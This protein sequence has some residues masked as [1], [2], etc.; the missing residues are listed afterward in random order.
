MTDA[1]Q[2]S[3][4]RHKLAENMTSL[5]RLILSV[6]ATRIPPDAP[7]VKDALK[8]AVAKSLPDMLQQNTVSLQALWDEVQLIPNV[9]PD[10]WA[11][12]FAKLGS[13]QQ[14]L[15]I[16]V[17]LPEQLETLGRMARERLARDVRL[18]LED[19]QLLLSTSSGELRPIRDKIA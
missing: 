5:S 8:A 15:A 1:L 9:S 7:H 11:P 16:T 3:A 12:A 19:L 14:E 18:N 2:N 17:V 13:W 4:N 10:V 6:L